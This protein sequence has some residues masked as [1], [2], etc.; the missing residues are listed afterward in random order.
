[1][2]LCCL[3]VYMV[4]GLPYLHMCMCSHYVCVFVGVFVYTYANVCDCLAI[5]YRFQLVPVST[6]LHISYTCLFHV[7]SVAY[8][9]QGD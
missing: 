4:F 5:I 8:D 3:C 7:F 1:M 2:Y 6:K 9:A